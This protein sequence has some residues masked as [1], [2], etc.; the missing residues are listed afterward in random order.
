VA[1]YDFDEEELRPYFAL[2]QVMEGLFAICRRLFG[3]VV[4][5]TAGVPVWHAEVKTFTIRDEATGHHLGSFY[6]DFYPREN[7]R[8]GAWMDSIPD[9]SAAR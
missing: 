7:K 4:E 8:G 2:P 9:G 5:E 6:S 1:L 3:I